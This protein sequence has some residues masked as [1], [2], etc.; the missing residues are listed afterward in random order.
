MTLDEAIKHASEVS[1]K[2]DCAACAA[3]HAQLSA[4]LKELKCIR[5][6]RDELVSALREI[7]NAC[8]SPFCKDARAARRIAR[9]ALERLK[10]QGLTT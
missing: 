4:W 2:S 6:T 1:C 8:H 10:E 7:E 9:N 3:E 5:R